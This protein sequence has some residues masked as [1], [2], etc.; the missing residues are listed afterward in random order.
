MASMQMNVR[1]DKE[2]KL[3]GDEAFES[4]GY[5]PSKIV[6]AVWSYGARNRNNRKRLRALTKLLEE[7]ESAEK[8]EAQKSK[9]EWPLSGP[10]LY[11]DFLAEMGITDPKPLDIDD[12]ELLW[13]AYLDRAE[14]KGWKY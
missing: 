4:I 8:E 6:Q 10:Q 5:T 12:D 9:Y 3:A 13:Q 2:D 1:I 7:T 11:L 14:E